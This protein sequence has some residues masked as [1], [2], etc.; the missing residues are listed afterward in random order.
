MKACLWVSGVLFVLIGCMHLLRVLVE[1]GHAANPMFYVHNLAL[2]FIC[3][4]LAA[5]GLI[6]APRPRAP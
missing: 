2:F 3:G 1:P 5:W 6:L 4:A